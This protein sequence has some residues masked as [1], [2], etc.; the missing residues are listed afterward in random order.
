[1]ISLCLPKKTAG[2]KGR[3][4]SQMFTPDSTS[5][6]HVAISNRCSG[7][8]LADAMDEIVQAEYDIGERGAREA[9]KSQTYRQAIRSVNQ[10][11]ACQSTSHKS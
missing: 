5:D 1:M 11:V 2:M 3:L 7:R 6:A 10:T 9:L 8:H 4:T